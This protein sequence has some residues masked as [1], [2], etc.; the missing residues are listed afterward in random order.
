MITITSND[1]IKLSS[2]ENYKPKILIG[3]YGE[4]T[5]IKTQKL[6]LKIYVYFILLFFLHR[7]Y[8]ILKLL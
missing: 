2:T 4:F 3:Q 7:N 8:N 6:L 5:E 1:T